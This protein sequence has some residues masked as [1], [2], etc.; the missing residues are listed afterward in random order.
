MESS[1]S[2]TVVWDFDW[3]LIN[4]NS[5]EFVPASLHSELIDFIKAE[6]HRVQWTKLMAEVAR[7]LAAAGHSQL[8]IEACLRSM[9]VFPE[10]LQTIRDVHACGYASQYVVSD[11]NTVYIQSFLSGHGLEAAI[12]SHRIHTNPSAWQS[13]GTHTTPVSG[14]GSGDQHGG[15]TAP[16]A[17]EHLL[18]ISPYHPF[19]SPHHGCAR[20]PV[21]L[22]KGQVLDGLGLSAPPPAAGAAGG[23][24]THAAVSEVVDVGI[25]SPHGADAATP[26]ERLRAI[27]YVGDGGGDLCPALRLGGCDVVLAREGYAL[28]KQLA[29]MAANP[30]TAGLVRA[31]VKTWRNG[32]EL[33]EHIMTS[34]A[35]ASA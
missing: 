33:R 4:C 9:P 24:P 10:V 35:S 2:F 22:C 14:V 32:A 7:R 31:R 20:C 28:A 5:D 30:A 26:P 11:A 21:N 34:L 12:P 16:A 1:S 15:T 23:T 19:D 17:A 25:P 3:S 13:Q 6:H 27:V 8:A 29:A 18:V